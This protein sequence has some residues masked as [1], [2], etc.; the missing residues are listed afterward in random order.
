MSAPPPPAAP[1]SRPLPGPLPGPR[2]RPAA[3]AVLAVLGLGV[4]LALLIVGV[5]RALPLP[6]G[7]LAE[8]STVVEFGDGTPG[9][10][11]LSADEKWRIPVCLSEIDPAYLR[12]LIHLEDRRFRRHLGIDPLAIARAAWTDLIHRR[13]VSGGSTITMQLVRVREP[14]PRTPGSK[15]AEAFRALQL[16]LH[17]SKDEIL[18][19]YL[20][21]VPYGKNVEGVEAA[22]LAYFGH[23]ATAL[24]AAEIA[25]LLAVPQNPT[26]RFP[27]ARNLARLA[28]ARDAIAA[29]L[30]AAGVLGGGG[31]SPA[32]VLAGVRASA[33]PAE[34]RPFPRLAPHA[35]AWLA[36]G[37]EARA[38][39]SGGRARRIRTTLDG[40]VQRLAEGVLAAARPELERRGIHNGAVVVVDH[41]T[42]EVRALVGNFDFFDAANGGQIIGFDNPRSPGSTLKPFLYAMAIDRGLLLPDFLLLDTPQVYGTYAPKNYDGHYAGL[43]RA[44]DALSRSL[45]VPFVR[46]MSLLRAERFIG[47]LRTMGVSSLRDESGYY[48]L[49]AAVGG[50][51]LTPLEL[52]GLYAMLAE[53]GRWAPLRWIAEQEREQA[54]QDG[55]AGT[56]R[57][58]AGV[59]GFAALSPGAAYLTRR[60]LAL[61]DRPDFPARRRFAVP[62]RIHW[63]T[64]TS[65]GHRDAWS[66]GSGPRY[67][68][69]VW[70][71]NFDNTPSASLVGADAAGPLLF[72]LLEALAARAEERWEE[73]PPADL[74]PVEVCAYSG[75]LPGPAC[76]LRKKVLAPAHSVPTEACPYHVAVDVD[77][78]TGLALTPE[79]RGGR[80]YRTESFVVWPASLGR[81][82]DDTHRRTPGPPA[83]AP[84][85]APAPS[86]EPPTI[87]SPPPHHVAL[88]APG[89]PPSRQEIPLA[90]EGAA[91]SELSWFVDGEYLGTVR[92]EDRLWWTPV[93]GVH[94]IVVSDASGRSARRTFE[95]R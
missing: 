85:C 67:T 75:R 73:P 71:G 37:G 30:I 64:G 6:D 94:E 52:A 26:R 2:F 77:E 84:G 59:T 69:V 79:C 39:R 95:V 11:A 43:V 76:P 23:R 91:R 51:E 8:G 29:R 33:V 44:E 61:K 10:V 80:A 56:V 4:A 15:L 28:W 3:R 66:V 74:V 49:S 21:H 46:L 24:S 53:D 13:V 45:N 14:R 42:R 78:R 57:R 16:E 35:A 27:A 54:Q 20:A 18:A 50:L 5:A 89:V 34:L 9:F 60:A 48:G 88:L 86:R 70:L 90:A 1:R 38:E 68:A 72:D 22:A 93:R 32:A 58:G 40:G 47:A 19:A 63:K 31:Q 82:L 25:T 41:R 92:A 83:W 55:G 7:F 65:F 12:A 62:P 36:S 81:W 17:L 87:V